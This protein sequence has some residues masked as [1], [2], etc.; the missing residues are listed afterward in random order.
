M[1]IF[2]VLDCSYL[3]GACLLISLRISVKGII[4]ILMFIGIKFLRPLLVAIFAFFKRTWGIMRDNDSDVLLLRR[5]NIPPSART[6]GA[7]L[8]SFLHVL[9]KYW[10]GS[11]VIVIDTLLRRGPWSFH[12]T[13]DDLI[14]HGVC[15]VYRRRLRFFLSY[16]EAYSTSEQGIVLSG[17]I[18]YLISFHWNA[19]APSMI[20]THHP[21]NP[22]VLC[23]RR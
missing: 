17:W 4:L 5:R 21:N 12:C 6:K 7:R 20:V 15:I 11:K 22:E 14:W 18:L 19:C 9:V 23:A 3:Q 2:F 16:P 1:R 8:A 13:K 10:Q